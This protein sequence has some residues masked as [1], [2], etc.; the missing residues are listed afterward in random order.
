[1]PIETSINSPHGTP[2]VVLGGR[3]P[4]LLT[5]TVTR[6]SVTSITIISL[7]NGNP[8][9]AAEPT[10]DMFIA[11]SPP[12]PTPAPI[13]ADG[14]VSEPAVVIIGVVLGL[15]CVL[16]ALCFICSRR[17]KNNNKGGS[18]SLTS[19]NSLR[20]HYP[21]FYK[22]PSRA[23]PGPA[24]P[25]GETGPQ[26]NPGRQGEQG[27]RGE[28]GEQ[29]VPVSRR[30]WFCPPTSFERFILTGSLRGS[31]PVDRRVRPVLRDHQ[32]WRG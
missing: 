23:F 10:T 18:S 1:M 25:R 11:S 28:R 4:S 20:Y 30:L 26:G 16:F 7:G 13:N 12:S 27:G 9:N 22:P 15:T 14:G 3:Q 2:T 17:R 19:S 21:Y 5:L 29:G 8:D 6:P 32:A 31:A 24:G